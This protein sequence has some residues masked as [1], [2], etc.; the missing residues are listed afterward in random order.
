VLAGAVG[1]ERD[2]FTKAYLLVSQV[3][4]GE[5][6]RKTGALTPILK[7]FDAISYRN[8]R[9]ALQ[10]WRRDG[11]YQVALEELRNVG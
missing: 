5:K 3:R 2:Q 4:E 6:T 8:A 7:L 1:M 11:A 10:Y 9:G